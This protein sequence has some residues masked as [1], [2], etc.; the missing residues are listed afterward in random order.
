MINAFYSVSWISMTLL[1][2]LTTNNWNVWHKIETKLKLRCQ[3]VNWNRGGH[4]FASF[5]KLKVKVRFSLHVILKSL[6]LRLKEPKMQ[7]D[8]KS[9]NSA[10]KKKKKNTPF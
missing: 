3:H 1:H 10:V 7:F 9:I 4:A 8:P 2:V 6:K 5:L